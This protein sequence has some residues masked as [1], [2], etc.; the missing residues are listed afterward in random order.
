MGKVQIIIFY[1]LVVLF[2]CFLAMLG[3][4]PPN[5]PFKTFFNAGIATI[6]LLAGREGIYTILP[7]H[8]KPGNTIYSSH[9]IM[10]D[11]TFSRFFAIKQAPSKFLKQSLLSLSSNECSIMEQAGQTLLVLYPDKKGSFEDIEILNSLQSLFPG[12]VIEEVFFE[13]LFGLP[14]VEVFPPENSESSLTAGEEKNGEHFLDANAE[15]SCSDIQDSSVIIQ[16]INSTNLNN[17]RKS[18]ILAPIVLVIVFGLFFIFTPF[19]ATVPSVISLLYL[20]LVLP[21]SSSQDDRTSDQEKV[22][23]K[24]GII[25]RSLN[26]IYFIKQA[27]SRSRMINTPIHI[28]TSKSEPVMDNLNFSRTSNNGLIASTGEREEKEKITDETT[29]DFSNASIS[30]GDSTAESRSDHSL[31]GQDDIALLKG[32]SKL[33]KDELEQNSQNNAEK[34]QSS[35][36]PNKKNALKESVEESSKKGEKAIILTNDKTEFMEPNIS[37]TGNKSHLKVSKD[38]GQEPKPEEKDQIVVEIKSVDLKNKLDKVLGNLS[39]EP[40]HKD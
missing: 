21:S 20:F 17:L 5:E 24:E 35:F 23:L 25:D 36:S 4:I 18:L 38:E 9:N 1:L 37:L 39:D 6:S 33:Y 3:F 27:L 22:S 19:S 16:G 15:S 34:A 29:L 30:D 31:S 14:A 12:L 10:V 7:E 8:L 13:N 32:L 40:T 2:L 11:K 26:L 28:N